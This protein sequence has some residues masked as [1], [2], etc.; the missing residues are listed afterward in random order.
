MATRI[1]PT[2]VNGGVVKYVKIPPFKP[3]A[4][5]DSRLVVAGDTDPHLVHHPNWSYMKKWVCRHIREARRYNNGYIICRTK[6]NG[7]VVMV[8]YIR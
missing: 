8:D 4:E 2:R 1:K 3:G 6:V 5:Y 7:T